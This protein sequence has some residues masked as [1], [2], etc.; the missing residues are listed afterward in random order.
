MLDLVGTA[1]RDA[2]LTHLKGLTAFN[3]RMSPVPGS[4]TLESKSFRYARLVA[5]G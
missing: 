1:V 5:S 2:G 4:V 3:G